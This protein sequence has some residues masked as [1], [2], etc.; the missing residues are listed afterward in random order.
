MCR[1]QGHIPSK[2]VGFDDTVNVTL[3]LPIGLGDHGTA[4]DIVGT[5]KLTRRTCWPRSTW[6]RKWPRTASVGAPQRA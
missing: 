5:A 4:Y 1:D 2:F 6:L 3:G